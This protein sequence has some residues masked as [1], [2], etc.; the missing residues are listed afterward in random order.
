MTSAQEASI[1]A[2]Q[3]RFLKARERMEAVERDYRAAHNEL[4]ESEYGRDR[5]IAKIRRSQGPRKES[6]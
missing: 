3:E 6:P 2:A 1:K 5:L 4:R